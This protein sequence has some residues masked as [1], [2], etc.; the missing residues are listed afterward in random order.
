MTTDRY[1]LVDSSIRLVAIVGHPIA[2]VKSPQ[3]FNRHFAQK[4][5]NKVM[6]PVDVTPEHVADFVSL[7]RG[8]QN[9]DGFVVTIPHKQAVHDLVDSMSDRARFLGAVNVVRRSADGSLHGDMTDGDGFTQAMAAHGFEPQGKTVLL[10]GA[11]AAGSAIAQALASVGV[12]VMTISDIDAGRVTALAA[13]L[14]QMFPHVEVEAVTSPPM[15]GFDLVVN[16]SPAGMDS[17][18]ASPVPSAIVDS[19]PA[20]GLAA[21]V[22]TS[23]EQTPFLVLA[24]SRGLKIQTG[25]DMAKAQFAA[26]GY[27]I[28][29]MTQEGDDV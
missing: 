6:I 22:I 15:R 12:A 1:P 7:V 8:W 5:I 14:R 21:D 28:G 17:G 29:I 25:A 13:R 26:L 18:D 10:V 3:N 24:A 2:Q 11:G 19:M 27:G 4:G 20:D 16:A 23:P 9:L